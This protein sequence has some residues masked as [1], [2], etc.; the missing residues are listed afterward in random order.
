[1]IF[2]GSNIQMKSMVN[3]YNIVEIGLE[4]NCASDEGKR[5]MQY[6]NWCEGAK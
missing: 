3:T 4:N 1:M 6:K 5:I 2:Y